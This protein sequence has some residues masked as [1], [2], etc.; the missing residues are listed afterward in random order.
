[1]TFKKGQSGNPNG[2]PPG[3]RKTSK[4]RDAIAEELP[5]IIDSLKTAALAGDTAAAK[6]LLDR[7]LAPLRPVELP[8]ELTLPDGLTEAGAA[9]LAA[10]GGGKVDPG[11]GA[12]LIAAIGSLAKV[13]ELDELAARITALEERQP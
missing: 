12:R 13:R 8:V 10:V 2:R 3:L 1:M 5:A 6:L 11:T 4:I 7:A 9:V